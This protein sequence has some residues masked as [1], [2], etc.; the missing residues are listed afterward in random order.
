MRDAIQ[1]KHGHLLDCLDLGGGFPSNSLLHGMAGPA[2]QVVPPIE[3]YADAITDVLN[4]LP[5]K[6]RPLLRLETGR[7][8]V[9]EAGYLLT[10]VV[11]VKGIHRQRAENDGLSAR[12]FKEQLIA[13]EDSKVNY[14]ADAGINLLYTSAW[15]RFN[16]QPSRLINEPP[17]PSRLYGSLCMAIDV[18]RD[19]IDLPPLE[20]GDVLS[21]HPVGAYNLSQSMQFIAYRPAVVLI[22]E[23]RT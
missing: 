18:I 12:D 13:G 7:H 1:R 14:I 16:V 2:E 10:S 15:Y 17:M 5:E 20:V 8:L 21:V 11:A 4:R 6:K 23:R 3:A 9:D 22:T 19:H